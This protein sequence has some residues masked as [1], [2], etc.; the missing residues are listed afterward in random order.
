MTTM[1]KT[2]TEKLTQKA[3]ITDDVLIKIHS[4]NFALCLIFREFNKKKSCLNAVICFQEANKIKLLSISGYI[5]K[6]CHAQ[7]L[8]TENLIFLKITVKYLK[9]YIEC[10]IRKKRL[11]NE[12][13]KKIQTCCI[14]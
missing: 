4:K 1:T 6:L 9:Y 12:Y 7:Y 10:S 2:F 3:Y 5:W 8:Q 14:F 11:L 13:L